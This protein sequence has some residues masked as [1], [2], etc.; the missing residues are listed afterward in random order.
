[1]SGLDDVHSQGA[2]VT[3]EE[4]MNEMREN[5]EVLERTT[6]E[7]RLRA[8]RDAPRAGTEGGGGRGRSAEAAARQ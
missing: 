1:M 2:S 7:Q 3:T 6:K 4:K 5:I 8:E